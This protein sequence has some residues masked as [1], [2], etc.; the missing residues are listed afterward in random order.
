MTWATRKEILMLILEERSRGKRKASAMRDDH[1]ATRFADTDRHLRA[2]RDPI[3]KPCTWPRCDRRKARGNPH[4]CEMHHGVVL[5]RD[6]RRAE[7]RARRR[8]T[9]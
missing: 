3:T 4:Y 6:R 2:N 1:L 5:A 9:P 7:R 8:R